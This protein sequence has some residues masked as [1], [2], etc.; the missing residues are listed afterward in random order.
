MRGVF[1]TKLNVKKLLPVLLWGAAAIFL[2]G[3]ILI[4]VIAVP[5]SNFAYKRVLGVICALLM[6]ILSGLCAL[7]LWLSRDTYPNYFL[8]DRKKKKNIPVE[9]LRFT[10]VSE[11][12][13]FLMLQIA[14]SPE[15][16]WK[17]DILLRGDE[18]YGYRCVYKPLVAYKMLFDLG[19]QGVD[20]GYWKFFREAPACNINSICETLE[21]V[22]EKKMMEVFRILVEREPKDNEKLKE[23][24]RKNVPYIRSKMVNYVVRHIELFY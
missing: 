23:F 16:L 17:S 2:I 10:Q 22:G 24:L 6:I 13:T 12:M 4:F 15:E 11:R 19:E 18:T 14:D 20:S 7:Y 21:R 5:R 9:K 3:A 8:F 1:V